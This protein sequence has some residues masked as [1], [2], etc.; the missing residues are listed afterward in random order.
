MH[1]VFFAAFKWGYGGSLRTDISQNQRGMHW[2][3][4]VHDRPDEHVSAI[5][6]DRALSLWWAR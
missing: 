2:V 6:S 3:G 5:A 1:Q 4:G